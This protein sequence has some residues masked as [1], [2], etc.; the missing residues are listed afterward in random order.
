MTV[1]M[2]TSYISRQTR[3]LALQE[4]WSAAF[5]AWYAVWTAKR[6]AR[7]GRR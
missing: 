5:A 6:I 1:V 3:P 7:G 2:N 4:R